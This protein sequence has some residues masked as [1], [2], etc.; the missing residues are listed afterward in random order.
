MHIAVY[1]LLSEN[2]SDLRVLWYKSCCEW[3]HSTT[4]TSHSLRVTSQTEILADAKENWNK[5]HI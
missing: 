3:P 4:S 5:Q 1:L 2:I